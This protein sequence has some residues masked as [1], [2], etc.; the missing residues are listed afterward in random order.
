[1]KD[2]TR[3]TLDLRRNRLHLGQADELLTLWPESN[4][5]TRADY[6]ILILKETDHD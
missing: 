6:I 4:E 2:N 1:M 3:D 5:E